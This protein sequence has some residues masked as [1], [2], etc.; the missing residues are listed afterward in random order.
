MRDTT[1]YSGNFQQG[2][3]YHKSSIINNTYLNT[4]AAVVEAEEL[5]AATA[6]LEK[7]PLDRVPDVAPLPAGSV[8]GLATNPLFV[9]RQ[10]DLQ[11]LAAALVAGTTAAIGQIAAATG[12]GGIG[13][14]QLASE[15]A[16]RYGCY[17]AGGVFWISFADASAIV[18]EVA[19]CGGVAGL[20]LADNFDAL[21]LEQQVTM[22]SAQWHNALPRLLVFDNCE[23]EALIEAWRPK[24]GGC[25]ILVTSR[26]VDWSPHLGIAPLAL[27]VL[28]RPESLAL[29][30]KHRPDLAADAPDLDAIAT[31]LGDLPLALHL[32]GS[33][34]RQYRHVPVG[35]PA[36]YLAALR[37]PDLL[38][39][40]SLTGSGASPTR[41]DQHLARSFA[42]SVE[43]L[44]PKDP[45]DALALDA[46][47]R[48][49]CF[50]AG[51]PVPRFLLLASLP[52]AEDDAA[53]MQAADALKRLTDLGLGEPEPDGALVLHRLL[54]AYVRRTVDGLPAARN[55]VERAVESVCDILLE[56]GYPAPLQAW[57]AQ[58]RAVAGAA[59]A[60]SSDNAANLQLSLGN[61]LRM[62]AAYDEAQTAFEQAVEIY[63]HRFGPNQPG[64]ATAINNLGL[65]LRERGDLEGAQKA[66]EQALKINETIYGLNNP[67]VAT[68]VNNQGAVLQDKGD[69]DGAQAAYERALTIDEATLGPDHP[70]V[71]RDIGNVG[72]VLHAKGDLIGAQ[73]AHERALKID[74]NS[75][76]PNH[77][78]VA[79][80]LSN[81]G[82]VLQGKGDFDGAQAALERALAIDEVAFGPNHPVVATRVNNL[83]SVL[84]AKGDLEG[85]QAAHERALKIDEA[86]H[87]PNHPNVAIRVSNLGAVLRDKGDLDGARAA[88]ERAL[89]ILESRL[90]PDHAR[91]RSVKKSLETVTSILEK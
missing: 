22:V 38:D 35:E 85:A 32:A 1:D 49:A 31:E 20:A 75:F 7:M 11:A 41:H 57:Q 60:E 23:D 78:K 90:G 59:V 43:Q 50:A 63:E 18:G 17:F 76:G 65:V 69:L 89:T 54:V 26:K 28:T 10:A 80:R 73:A 14:T 37:A 21:P 4:P 84:Y 40:P 83:G 29:L 72:A 3:V 64:T 62:I 33:F 61:F 88:F 45:V 86:T 16:H 25:R 44:N 34:L 87:G 74:E 79:V 13:K 19:R 6:H 5:A 2:T 36:R 9:G 70:D 46:L 81:L 68:I 15:F 66:F 67:T 42:L 52:I 71:A 91:T 47:A 51:E 24:T 82:P 58:L 12:L 48:L 39:H 30:C 53:Q 55:A 27:G 8:I 77:P 56:D